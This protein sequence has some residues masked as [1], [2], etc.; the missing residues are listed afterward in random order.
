MRNRAAGAREGTRDARTI[1]APASRR[2]RA[3][4]A[5]ASRPHRA[6]AIDFGASGFYI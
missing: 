1:I 4:V 2:H 5:P 3:R 6:R